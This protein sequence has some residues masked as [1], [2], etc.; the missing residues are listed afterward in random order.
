MLSITDTGVGMDQRVLARV[1]EPFF[2]TK[3]H[4]TGLG[5]S[6]SYGIIKQSCGDIRVE[7][8][9]SEGTTFQICLPVVEQT[10]E[11]LT[12]TEESRAARGTETILLVEDE[13]G[14]RRVL[15][16]M[17][18]RHGYKVLSSTSSTDALVVAEQHTGAI[19]LLIT[20]VVMP[21]M[22]GRK[23][24]ECLIQHRPDMRVLYVSG[25]GD[26]ASGGD[27]ALLQKPFSTQELALKIREVLR[28][29]V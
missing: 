24:A 26:P 4:G 10:E 21:G 25:Y 29:T 18:Q 12:A 22:S 6:T 17:L 14:V 15:E 3:E 2:T 19:H 9:P 1:F 8:T 23:M 20:D 5:L 16:T 13:D 27:A 11:Q 7:S 28:D